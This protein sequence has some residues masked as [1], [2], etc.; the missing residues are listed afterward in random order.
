LDGKFIEILLKFFLF[1]GS[2][3]GFG[4]FSEIQGKFS[5]NGEFFINFFSKK[6]FKEMM[7]QLKHIFNDM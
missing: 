5:E 7:G 6:F 1:L 4:G 3:P 2:F